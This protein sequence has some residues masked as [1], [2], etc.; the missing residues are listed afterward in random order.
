MSRVVESVES[1]DE[2]PF[3]D[4][5]SHPCAMNTDLTEEDMEVGTEDDDG[6]FPAE[7]PLD[8]Y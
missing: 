6:K 4:M 8:E 7:C 3:K 2:C 1:C 5:D